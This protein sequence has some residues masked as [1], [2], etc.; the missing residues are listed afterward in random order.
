MFMGNNERTVHHCRVE[1]FCGWSEPFMEL[2]YISRSL[3]G[4]GTLDLDVVEMD[5]GQ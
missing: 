4:G 1:R 3:W 2:D 5:E